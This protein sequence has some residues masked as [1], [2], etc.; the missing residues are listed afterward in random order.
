[1]RN[2]ANVR[3]TVRTGSTPLLSN[4][5]SSSRSPA[6]SFKTR[7]AFAI[8]KYGPRLLSVRVIYAVEVLVLSSSDGEEMALRAENQPIADQRG[9]GER[10]FLQVVRI[11]QLVFLAGTNHEGLALLV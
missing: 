6:V 2:S 4:S 1:M 9:R 3:T 10:H 8:P 7:A 11:Q 5:R